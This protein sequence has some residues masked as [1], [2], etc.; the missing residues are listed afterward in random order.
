MDHG[1]WVVLSQCESL[2]ETWNE[3]GCYSEA[4]GVLHSYLGLI[5]L[6]I[7]NVLYNYSNTDCPII[8]VILTSIY[9]DIK[10][11]NN[12]EELAEDNFVDLL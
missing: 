8:E 3:L 6:P 5:N 9:Y 1:G 2:K 11:Y 7:S 12:M 4:S 10:L